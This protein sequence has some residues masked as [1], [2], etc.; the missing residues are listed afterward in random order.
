MKTLK[1]IQKGDVIRDSYVENRK[2]L[3]RI[4]DCV[5]LSSYSNHDY[6]A[7]W[8]TIKELE[9]KGFTLSDPQEVE[10]AIKVLERAG[11]I[12]DGKIISS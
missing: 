9:N 8:F 2:V 12:K 3:L 4:E 10:E 7:T 5:L 11:K 1:D 6:A